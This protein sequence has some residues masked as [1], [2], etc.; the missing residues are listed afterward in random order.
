MVAGEIYPFSEPLVMA[1]KKR[2]N[3]KRR[4]EIVIEDP[5]V[6]YHCGRSGLE[7]EVQFCP[8]C[9]FPQ[10]KGE[11]EQKRFLV[12]QRKKRSELDEARANIG[13]AQNFLYALAVINLIYI[14]SPD[15][16]TR[17]SSGIMGVSFIVLGFFTPKRPFPIILAALIAYGSFTLLGFI[18]F[19]LAN[20]L[21]IAFKVMIIAALVFGLNS[22]RKAEKLEKELNGVRL[23]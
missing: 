3:R 11:T 1:V 2:K 13:R 14:I 15:L 7:S 10:G 21:T 5:S 8:D 9:G 20:V 18:L 23:G 16:F 12:A 17:I 4:K 6:C 19:P 22:A